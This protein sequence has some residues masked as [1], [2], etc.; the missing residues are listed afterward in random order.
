MILK[1]FN[2][3]I[4]DLFAIN[5]TIACFGIYLIDF[6]FGFK[7]FIYLSLNKIEIIFFGIQISLIIFISTL[8]LSYFIKKI[9]KIFF[10][11]FRALIFSITFLYLYTFVI[12]FSDVNYKNFLNT[13]FLINKQLEIL[14]YLLPFII[15]FIL[16]ILLKKEHIKK[17]NKFI[18]ILLNIFI[19][20]T[21]LRFVDKAEYSTKNN[22]LHFENI[23]SKKVDTKKDEKKIFFL[24]FDELDFLYVKKNFDNLESLKELS[25][26][27]F[28]HE[29]FF[30]PG[31]YTIH[32]VPPIL[33]GTTYKKHA[34]K[35]GTIE[36]TNLNDKKIL[37]SE[38]NTFFGDIKK[39]GYNFSLFGEY[40]PYC[41][42]FSSNECYD[43]YLKKQENF[44]YRY[45][46]KRFLSSLY[47]SYFINLD[48]FLF[49]K[50]KSEFASE[51][52]S[53]QNKNIKIDNNIE[54]IDPLSH[55]QFKLSKKMVNSKNELVFIHY[56]YPHPPLKVNFLEKKID[57]NDYEKNLILVDMTIKNIAN[58][59]KKYEGAFL[60]ITS[61]H[62]LKS[63]NFK[64][65]KKKAYPV[66]FL[67]K[68]IGDDSSFKNKQRGHS[69]DIRSLINQY[70]NDSI[71]S[72][73]DIKLFFDL[74]VSYD[75][76]IPI[77]RND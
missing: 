75:K 34:F 74:N 65:E 13:T 60:I 25:N 62:W 31:S 44:N 73:N 21:F 14:V 66:F 54:I 15:G 43:H 69:K 40:L 53:K 9:N 29:N 35:K 61:D 1:H 76:T 36:I 50:S 42:L 64:K 45:Q 12:R 10:N 37:F 72:N 55:Y 6:I 70:I 57:I 4:K 58:E 27:S 24:L 47:I 38:E 22:Y 30:P 26:S 20:L 5:L 46:L 51:K 49:L 2:K 17:I 68:I 63:R 3:K 71:T 56:A 8:L 7:K 28:V 52:P 33:M 19:I 18:F 11:I 41:R 67:A 32:S 39:K 23:K 77:Y 59:I 16:Y 48:R